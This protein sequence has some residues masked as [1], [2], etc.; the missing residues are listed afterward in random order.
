MD[1]ITQAVLGASLQGALLGRWQGRKALLYGAML[2]TV[3]DMD[4]VLDYGDAV[5]DMTYHR[6]FSHSLLVLGVLSVVLAWLVRRWRPHPHYSGTRLWLCIWL[7]L[8]THVLLDAFTT[9]GTQLFWPLPTPPVAISSIFIIDPLYTLP[10][11]LAVVGAL[12]LG[13]KRQAGWRL[14]YAALALSSVYLAST[15][16]GKQM[17]EH[18][19]AQALAAE[20]IQ[21]EATFTSPTPFNTV[22]WRV[23][24]VAGDDYYE[25]LTGWFDRQPLQLERLPRHASAAQPVLEQS[26]QHQR[27]RWFTQDVLRYD[28]IDNQWVVT[29]LRL[30]MTGYH[31]FR[32]ALARV[33]PA[34]VQLIEHA[35]LW[36][37][38]DAD[39]EDLKALQRRALDEGYPL[40]LARLAAPLAESPAAP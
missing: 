23:V 7:I 10:L 25:G 40:S 16:A 12:M 8:T 31:P 6:G 1:S 34:G 15:L 37:T 35:E 30:G 20:G 28:L 18:R 39:L 22:L 4:V 14:Q 21:A 38:P 5:A 33:G 11:L 3:P 29:D 24:A 17:A 27:L 26:P 36:P 13:F 9:Y 32:F 2:G 19:L